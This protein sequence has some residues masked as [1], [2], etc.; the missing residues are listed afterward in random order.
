MP[1]AFRSE[2]LF[3][4]ML[5]LEGDESPM[6]GE[7]QIGRGDGGGVVSAARMAATRSIEIVGRNGIFKE[8]DS[9]VGNCKAEKGPS[10]L[11]AGTGNGVEL[12]GPMP[13]EIM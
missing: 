8:G 13:K 3:S 10:S 2:F 6:F 4:K 7:H 12:R 9:L 5:R 1:D 11:A